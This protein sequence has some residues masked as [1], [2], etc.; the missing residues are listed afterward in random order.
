MSVGVAFTGFS[1]SSKYSLHQEG[2]YSSFLWMLP[3]EFLIE[4]VMLKLFPRVA[5]FPLGLSYF[6][7]I[8][9]NRTF[10]SFYC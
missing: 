9:E 5:K 3:I 2:I 7:E 10:D 8:L 6:A 4:T 1:K